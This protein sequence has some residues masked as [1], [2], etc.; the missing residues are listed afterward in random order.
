MSSYLTGAR[1]PA[2]DADLGRL[3]A[4]GWPGADNTN[5]FFTPQDFFDRNKI[6]LGGGGLPQPLLTA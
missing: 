1:L 6:N 5:H 3:T 4:K 2:A